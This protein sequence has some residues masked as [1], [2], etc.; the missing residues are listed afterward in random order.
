MRYNYNSSAKIPMT[1]KPPWYDVQL[2]G[3]IMV[4][5]SLWCPTKLC[6]FGKHLTGRIALLGTEPCT[7]AVDI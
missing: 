7:K 6:R 4:S 2:K 3:A 5:H 1:S